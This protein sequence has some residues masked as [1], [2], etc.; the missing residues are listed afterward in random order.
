MTEEAPQRFDVRGWWKFLHGFYLCFV[1]LYP[2]LRDN[3][4]EDNSFFHH[5]MTLLPIEHKINLSTSFNY[6]SKFAKQLS[7]LVPCT[8]KSSMNTSIISSMKSENIAI[9]HL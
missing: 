1:H 2:S 5:E 7:K 3:M 9:M 8:E 4:T 6:F